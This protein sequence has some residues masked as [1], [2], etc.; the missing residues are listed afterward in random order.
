MERLLGQGGFGLVYLAYDEQLRRYVAVKVPHD[1]LIRGQRMPSSISRRPATSP[2]WTIPTSSPST[3]S[4]GRT[5]IPASS[6]RSSSTARTSLPGSAAGRYTWRQAAELVVTVAEALHHAHKQGL[7]H[8][9]VKP[10]NILI[11]P[12]G[13]PF[14][15]DFGLALREEDLG[16]GPRYAG[17]P[18]T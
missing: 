17:T 3:T 1:R 12:T 11:D 5:S 10:G 4:A 13:K 9:D 16:K 2:A 18:P 14:V 7:V 6:S 15:V 8:R